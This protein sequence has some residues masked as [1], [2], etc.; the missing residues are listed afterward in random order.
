MDIR[1]RTK[2]LVATVALAGAVTAGTAGV[3]V[4]ADGGDGTTTDP[5]AQGH[6]HPRRAIRALG[7]V[8]ADTIG[9]ERYELREALR[10]GQSISE[11]AQANGVDPQAVVDALLTAIN[12]RVDRRVANGWISEERGAEIK[13]K[14]AE[15]VQ[16]LVDRHFGSGAGS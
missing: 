4:A 2:Q 12:D 14:A 16:Q 11:V 1:H 10:S 8:V 5:S 3:A 7:T 13:E 15:R 6:R 9:I